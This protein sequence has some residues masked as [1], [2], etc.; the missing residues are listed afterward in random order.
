V[1]ESYI[2]PPALEGIFSSDAVAHEGGEDRATKNEER[3]SSARSCFFRSQAL[4]L[5]FEATNSACHLGSV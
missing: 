5:R 2:L 1:V 3:D 4:R